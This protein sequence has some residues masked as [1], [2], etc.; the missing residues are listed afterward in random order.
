MVTKILEK[1]FQQSLSIVDVDLGVEPRIGLPGPE[2]E[3]L[4]LIG[5]F[6]AR[7]VESQVLI[8]GQAEEV[9]QG[10]IYRVAP[11]DSLFQVS[12]S[13]AVHGILR[14]FPRWQKVNSLLY[15]QPRLSV[16][17]LYRALLVSSLGPR[18]LTPYNLSTNM[19][20]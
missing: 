11:L 4:G 3:P 8:P 12:S 2:Q 17:Y 5:P 13:V 19:M 7:V 20:N 15:V 16:S 18:Q 6:V 14:A 9:L 1:I 10:L